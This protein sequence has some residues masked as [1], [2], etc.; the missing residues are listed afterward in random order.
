M[1][2]LLYLL[3]V[4]CLT[5]TG[6]ATTHQAPTVGQ[7]ID[8]SYPKLQPLEKTPPPA[9]ACFFEHP[10]ALAEIS[11]QPFAAQ[12][13]TVLN[14][15]AES[16]ENVLALVQPQVSPLL[17][18]KDLDDVEVGLLDVRKMPFYRFLQYIQ[19]RYNVDIGYN[20]KTDIVTVQKY[21]IRKIIIPP[22]LN[23]PKGVIGAS[24]D[25]DGV[26]VT[27][28][29]DNLK[30]FVLTVAKGLG[31]D[32]LT[33]SETTGTI[34]YRGRPH[35]MEEFTR[36]IEKE[37]TERLKFVTIHIM[38]LNVTATKGFQRDLNIEYIPELSALGNNIY[39]TFKLA[40]PT[41]DT[42]SASGSPLRIPGSLNAPTALPE[43]MTSAIVNPD[44]DKFSAL[45]GILEKWGTAEVLQAP[46]VMTANG[47]PVSFKMTEETGYWQPGELNITE[48]NDNAPR[49]IEE[50]RPEFVTEEVGLKLVIRPKIIRDHSTMQQ[51]VELDIHLEDSSV[52]GAITTT[53]QRESTIDPVILTKPVK[54][55]K[56]LSSRAILNND[57]ML[58]LA[59]MD[60]KESSGAISGLP[61][62]L[63]DKGVMG[64]VLSSKKD[65][66]EQTQTWIVIN[67]VLPKESR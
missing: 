13:V 2:R 56:V 32:I 58:M 8:K 66:E 30:D 11:F 40:L 43:G 5:L 4:L 37:A 27:A 38:I 35:E 9:V 67:A 20:A 63:G 23:S 65:N 48:A 46:A 10:D 19:Q 6:C 12:P 24:K 62:T 14:S 59:R 49:R 53:W 15:G 39:G 44:R 3:L 29:P 31:I 33:F 18:A 16:L 42:G 7:I 36:I 25:E 22:I 28:E 17:V 41:V 55:K 1:T 61:G 57:E 60:R 64:G 54:T 52:I 51:M 50:E 21:Q 26:S 47:V 34:Q 45:L